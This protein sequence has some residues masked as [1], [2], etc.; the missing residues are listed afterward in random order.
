MIPRG[1]YT[2]Q[3]II[4][5]PLDRSRGYTMIPRRV[6]T[7]LGIIACSLEHHRTHRMILCGVCTPLQNIVC[8]VRLL[9]D[10]RDDSY[11]GLH[12]LSNHHLVLLD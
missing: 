5:C 1:V 7:P 8:R 12:S 6:C 9:C 3:V 4:M 10:P 11:E 2:S